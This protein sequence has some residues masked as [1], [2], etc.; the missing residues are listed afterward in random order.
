MSLD[1]MIKG[2]CELAS[3]SPS[4]Q[5]TILPSLVFIVFEEVEI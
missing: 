5:V 4:M 3:E 1:H 2:T